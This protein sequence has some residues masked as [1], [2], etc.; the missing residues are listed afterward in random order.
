L[1]QEREREGEGVRENDPTLAKAPT[2]YG[3]GA[4]VSP[5]E[6]HTLSSL[7]CFKTGQVTLSLGLA[8]EA[9]VLTDPPL[10][11]GFDQSHYQRQGHDCVKITKGD[12]RPAMVY[13]QPSA[14][15]PLLTTTLLLSA[16]CVYCF[17]SRLQN[18]EFGLSCSG[19]RD[20]LVGRHFVCYACFGKYLS[21]ALVPLSQS[22]AQT[23]AALLTE[24]G[25]IICTHCA[26]SDVDGKCCVQ[27]IGYE[28]YLPRDQLKTLQEIKAQC[29]LRKSWLYPAS[30]C[31]VS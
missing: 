9:N 13:W 26:M 23:M 27:W 24:N 30:K 21:D 28:D 12:T 17:Q 1:A 8:F 31:Q 3:D 22:N 20:G 11:N 16:T 10:L 7:V 29:E 2:Q 5:F 4:M 25:E 15:L 6:P 18:Y 19:S 14:V